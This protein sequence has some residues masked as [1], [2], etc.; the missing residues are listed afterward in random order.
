[1]TYM[2]DF[3]T[4]REVTIEQIAECFL[5]TLCFSLKFIYLRSLKAYLKEFLCL[6]VVQLQ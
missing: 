5:N 2:N 6:E 1:M 3:Y 4:D